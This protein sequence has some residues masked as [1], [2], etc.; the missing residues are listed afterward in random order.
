MT[1]E[2]ITTSAVEALAQAIG[3]PLNADEAA[4]LT[5]NVR[6]TVHDIASLDSMDLK[7]VEPAITFSADPQGEAR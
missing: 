3:I 5:A 4:S 6:A 2:T 7:D 1:D